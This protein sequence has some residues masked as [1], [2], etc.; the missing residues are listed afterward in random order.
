M[1]RHHGR[2][3]AFA[4]LD[5]FAASGLGVDALVTLAGELTPFAGLASVDIESVNVRG[6]TKKCCA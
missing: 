2:D 4:S 5:C 1:S 3:D 6:R